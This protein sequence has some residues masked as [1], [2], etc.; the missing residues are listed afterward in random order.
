M[1]ARSRFG[2]PLALKNAEQGNKEPQPMTIEL[3]KSA[4]Y[5]CSLQG[6]RAIE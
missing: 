2:D 6:L 1:G 5:S 3:A 4:Y